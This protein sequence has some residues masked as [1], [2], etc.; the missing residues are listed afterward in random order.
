VL[1]NHHVPHRA[2]D[3]AELQSLLITPTEAN[4]SER[5]NIELTF[6]TPRN[7]TN[8]QWI[9]TFAVDV[10]HQ[11]QRIEIARSEH[12][13]YAVGAHQWRF[14]TSDWDL[15]SA[16]QSTLLNVGM[17]EIRLTEVASS[18]PRQVDST[19]SDAASPMV[20][21]SAVTGTVSKD[22]R[23]VWTNPTAAGEHAKLDQH[24]PPNRAPTSTDVLEVKLVTQVEVSENGSL[25]RR[26]LSPF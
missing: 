14:Q 22:V 17:V 2:K 19:I 18:A 26:I 8:A 7:L 20:T 12:S 15:R 5:L 13:N 16:N 10:A 11:S 21:D 9:V 3:D 6:R 4:I 24:H 25:V 23:N 1:A